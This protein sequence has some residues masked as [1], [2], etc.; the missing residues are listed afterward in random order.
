MSWRWASAGASYG[1]AT[2]L[3]SRHLP[4]CLPALPSPPS[5][6]EFAGY[7]CNVLEAIVGAIMERAAHFLPGL[8][9]VQRRDISVRVGP[10]PYATVGCTA[11]PILQ[12]ASTLPL[13]AGLCRHPPTP[14]CAACSHACPSL[15][16]WRITRLPDALCDT[17][18]CVAEIAAIACWCPTCVPFSPA[19]LPAGGC[20]HGGACAGSGGAA[21]GCRA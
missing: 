15:C 10:R 14:T 21:G 11:N 8:T 16:S 2:C 4:R 5:H 12:P 1:P 6:R 9:A 17:A 3:P 18:L 13:N 19:C 7:D 20:A